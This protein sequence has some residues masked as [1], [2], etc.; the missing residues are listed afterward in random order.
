MAE[1]KLTEDDLR[2]LA[3]D[4]KVRLEDPVFAKW[5]I[6]ERHELYSKMLMPD[7]KNEEVL[8]LRRQIIAVESIALKLKSF[9]D[10]YKFPPRHRAA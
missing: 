6:S 10:R 2:N 1:P 5:L 8:E 9:L 7:T 4:C 3:F